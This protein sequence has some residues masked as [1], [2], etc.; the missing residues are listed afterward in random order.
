MISYKHIAAEAAELARQFWLEIEEELTRQAAQSRANEPARAG[1]PTKRRLGGNE[2]LRAG[3]S[4]ES[5]T[6]RHKL[7]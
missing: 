5:H 7:Y 2:V 4:A 6:A 1:L 3:E